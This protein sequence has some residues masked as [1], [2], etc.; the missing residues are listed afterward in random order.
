MLLASGII[1]GHPILHLLDKDGESQPDDIAQKLLDQALRSAM[2]RS[3]RSSDEPKVVKKKDLAG[4][5]CPMCRPRA[6][7]VSSRWKIGH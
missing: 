5:G 1:P 3:E 4:C 2:A 6:N 7:T